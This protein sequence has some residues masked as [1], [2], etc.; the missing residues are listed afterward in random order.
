MVEANEREFEWVRCWS[1]QAFVLLISDRF[2]CC[3]L[4]P[5][6][7]REPGDLTSVCIVSTSLLLFSELANHLRAWKY[8]FFFPSHDS[9]VHMHRRNDEVETLMWQKGRKTRSS[10]GR[11]SHHMWETT[12]RMCVWIVPMIIRCCVCVCSGQGWRDCPLGGGMS[13]LAVIKY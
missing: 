7:Q 13:C 9:R 12:T 10:T 2:F 11:E 1:L 3:R 4:S 8:T 5:P 6:Q